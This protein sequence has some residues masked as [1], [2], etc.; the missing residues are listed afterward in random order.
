MTET[1]QS[2][3]YCNYPKSLIELNAEDSPIL[4]KL[5][6]YRHDNVS[7]SEIAHTAIKH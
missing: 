1:L 4:L 5:G 2:D 6:I 3:I 7:E